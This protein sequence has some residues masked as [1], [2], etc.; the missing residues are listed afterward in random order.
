MEFDG[1]VIGFNIFEAM[2]YPLD[3][4]TCFSIDVLDTLAQEMLD[5]MKED[6]LA[7]TLE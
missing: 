4:H 7:T 5:I 1:D 2:R 3:V 6:T